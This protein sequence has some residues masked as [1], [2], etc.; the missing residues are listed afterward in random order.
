MSNAENNDKS[1]KKSD[2]TNKE[3]LKKEV[4][5]LKSEIEELKRMLQQISKETPTDEKT[6]KA[7]QPLKAKKKKISPQTRK[8]EVKIEHPFKEFETLITDYVASIMDSVALGLESALAG[9]FPVRTSKRKHSLQKMVKKLRS[10]EKLPLTDEELEDFYEKAAKLASALDDPVRLKI[11]RV[12]EKQPKYPGEL[13]EETKTKGGQF[14]HHIQILKE[15]GLIGQEVV[16]GRYYITQFGRE[17]LKLIEIL[18]L[19]KKQLMTLQQKTNEEREEEDTLS[20][21]SEDDGE[22]VEIQW[23][24]EDTEEE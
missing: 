16:R 20:S 2:E 14:A 5:S 22:E 15:S 18:Y 9:V 21:N 17:A 6:E 13:A 10:F 12:L 4:E 3:E 24:D 8:V 23:M 1:M 7:Q 11:L 19:R